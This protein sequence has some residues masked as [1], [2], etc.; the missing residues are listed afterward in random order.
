MKLGDII[1]PNLS[2]RKKRG[3]LLVCVGL[4]VGGVARE[5]VRSQGGGGVENLAAAGGT[6]CFLIGLYLFFSKDPD[7]PSLLDDPSSPEPEPYRFTKRFAPLSDDG[8]PPKKK[9]KK[10]KAPV[11]PASDP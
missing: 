4:V 3:R 6:I 8:P 11:E 10:R 7:P 9:K 2:P 5:V 1:S